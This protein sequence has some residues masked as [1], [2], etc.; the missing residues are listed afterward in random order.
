[1]PKFILEDVNGNVIK[2]SDFQGKNVYIQFIDHSNYDD[3]KLIKD[4]HPN[5]KNEDLVIIVF[6]DDLKAFKMR[7]GI[8]LH[9]FI[10]IE[11][12]YDKMKSK[13]KSPEKGG[14][15]YLFDK[16]GFLVTSGK[17]TIGY[18][19]GPKVFLKQLVKNIYLNIS[20]FIPENGDIGNIKWFQEMHRIIVNKDNKFFVISLFTSICN[21]CFNGVIIDALNNIN[22][23]KDDSLFVVG[24][25][26][27][28]F[29]INDIKSL[30][31]QMNIYFPL[32]IASPELS[33][34]WNY[35]ISEFKESDLNNIVFIT[36]KSG[37]ILKIFHNNCDCWNTFTRYINSLK[38]KL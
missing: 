35:F 2:D 12:S 22:N 31:S 5:W 36:E 37:K 34:K 6:S 32:M 19:E 3:I 27:N 1:M 16:N 13:F 25:L 4:I 38:R 33:K 29:N 20:D 28:K 11:S 18:E 7:S 21:G 23:N 17:N 24:V 30:R 14:A 15:Y 26:N 10:S 8:D 9:D